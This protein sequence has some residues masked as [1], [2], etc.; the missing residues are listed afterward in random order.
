MNYTTSNS[1]RAYRV[2]TVNDGDPFQRRRWMESMNARG[3]K[4]ELHPRCHG[5]A[6][7]FSILLFYLAEAVTR[8]LE[9]RTCF[10]CSS[11]SYLP[12]GFI[13]RS[14]RTSSAEVSLIYPSIREGGIDKMARFAETAKRKEL[15]FYFPLLKWNGME[16]NNID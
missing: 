1:H 14:I 4:N 5:Q 2:R 12:Y 13:D 3:V 16:W 15:K 6:S 8:W 9:L 11:S 10:Q 7:F